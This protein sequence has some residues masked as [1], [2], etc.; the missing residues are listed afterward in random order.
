MS[1]LGGSAIMKRVIAGLFGVLLPLPPLAAQAPT[2]V[3]PGPPVTITVTPGTAPPPTVTINLLDR[4][5][6]VTPNRCGC[7]H[8][9]GGNIDVAQPSP[10]TVVV[11]M[12]GICVATGQPGHGSLA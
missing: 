10:D 9:G 11:T 1:A 5:G 4:H 7:N 2:T 6:H 3:P 8:T 12:G